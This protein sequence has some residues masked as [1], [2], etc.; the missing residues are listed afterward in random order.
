MN[1]RNGYLRWRGA[2][3]IATTVCLVLLA[4]SVSS[5]VG[6]QSGEVTLTK[7]D[8]NQPEAQPGTVLVQQ[9]SALPNGNED[10]EEQA[11]TDL[12][13]RSSESGFRVFEAGSSEDG[14]E[15]K[16]C[17]VQAVIDEENPDELV[18]GSETCFVNESSADEFAIGRSAHGVSGATGSKNPHILGKHYTGLDFS[19][20]SLTITGTKDC[21]GGGITLSLNPRWNNVIKSTSNGCSR[22]AHY[23]ESQ[24]FI[25]RGELVNTT[26]VGG[27]IIFRDTSAGVSGIRYYGT[28]NKPVRLVALEV[29]QGLQDWN[30]SITLVRGRKTFVRA[31]FETVNSDEISQISGRL[32]LVNCPGQMLPNSSIGPINHR[33]I[34]LVRSNPTNP[35]N[36]VNYYS[37]LN[38]SLP[39]NWSQCNGTA[40][41][42]LQV[43]GA[44]RTA[45]NESSTSNPSLKSCFAFV[46]IQNVSMPKIMM[47]KLGRNNG[48][49]PYR[50][51]H[52][53][54]REQYGRIYSVMPIP[55]KEFLEFSSNF[56]DYFSDKLVYSNN[57]TG[58]RGLIDL[59]KRMNPLRIFLARAYFEIDA[60]QLLFLGVLPREPND[61][62]DPL[63][64]AG[65]YGRQGRGIP[66]SVASWFTSYS[67]RNADL[68]RPRNTGAHELG[69][70]LGE[71]HATDSDGKVV[72]DKDT[73]SS[74][75]LYPYIYPA[76]P[77]DEAINSVA[78]L[79]LMPPQSTSYTEVWGL[80]IRVAEYINYL[81]D[82]RL[83][84]IS[85]HEVY[86]LMSYCDPNDFGIPLSQGVWMDK[87]HYQRII[88]SINERWENS[89][90]TSDQGHPSD[91]SVS[92]EES[93][94]VTVDFISGDIV[95]SGAEF[96]SINL[97]PI[98]S[99]D[100]GFDVPNSKTGD[101]SLELHDSSGNTL[102][103]ISFETFGSFSEVIDGKTKTTEHFAFWI[104][105]P[106]GYDS[107]AVTKSGQTLTTI[108]VSTNSPTISIT[109]PVAGQ[110]VTNN[111]IEIAWTANDP[112][113]DDLT[114]AVM[115]STDGGET[116]RPIAIGYDKTSLNLNL[117]S[118]PGSSEARFIVSVSDGINSTFASSPIVSTPQHA[119][120]IEIVAPTSGA[121]VT[122]GQ[123]FILSAEGYDLE[124]GNL[125]RSAFTWTSSLSGYLGTGDHILLSAT[126]LATGT[127]QIAVTATDSSGSSVTAFTRVTI[128]RTNSIPVAMDDSV[129]IELGESVFIDVLANDTDTEK[130]IDLTT[131]VVS[132]A[133]SLGVAEVTVSSEGVTGIKYTNDTSGNDSFSYQICDGLDRCST[134]KV[135]VRAGLADCTILGTEENDNLM[136]TTG[137]DI[138]C[139]LGGNDT[140][141]GDD[142]D[143]I[144]RGGAGNDSIKGGPGNDEIYGESG[145]DLI[146]G[147]R[148]EDRLF[149]GGDSDEMYGSSG[150]DFLSGG[151]GDDKLHGDSEN[152]I[153]EGGEGSDDLRGGHGD[154]I[155]R[156]NQGDDTIRGTTGND[157]IHGGSG[158]DS[159]NGGSGNDRIFG[160]DDP[161]VIYADDGDDFVSGGNGSD[162]IFGGNG[163]DILE[164]DDG[165]DEIRGGN[166]QDTIRGG[167][168]NDTIRGN[169]G[170]DTIIGGE[171]NNRILGRTREDRVL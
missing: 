43:I 38:F 99:L 7:L 151:K 78:T 144:I 148:G 11:S 129:D 69:H 27:N 136:G 98:V 157:E 4:A 135:R 134:A 100:S 80:D 14:G 143:D 62:N 51:S 73:E 121:V 66:G 158:S 92:G 165:H 1:S 139:G 152:D 70:L 167:K 166:G 74:G 85:P 42:R 50:V 59:N 119:P 16:H 58:I 168:G 29:T 32:H 95:L 133:P 146:N 76:P 131:F 164:G 6:A 97:D 52:A 25:F 141:E 171:G 81:N 170:A 65:F 24:R 140:I 147:N 123:S 61:E 35:S 71:Y 111:S 15:Y 110:Q 150:K 125:P 37:S 105:D 89:S 124:D 115:Y 109:K 156:G 17:V 47:V 112:D 57:L 126:E 21:E 19:G 130:D 18:L 36:R 23:S 31:F 84:V 34:I 8:F 149:G 159:I 91:A 106:P 79:G 55:R 77:N 54:L 45:C 2:S 88:N 83:A 46:S 72:C 118:I 13:Q 155:I 56:Q 30:N 122:G 26:G 9:D 127:H 107:I 90:H 86:S 49:M 103:S 160:E 108:Q 120:E 117:A 60:D 44:S 94:R 68:G 10:T 114:Y 101:Y 48:D 12:N 169:A 132:E 41:L 93:T 53:E 20:S 145:D 82:T 96:E 87:Y 33:G 137:N 5:P 161:D 162:R 40:T 39:D 163:V 63:G 22:I 102:R 104:N 116:Y 113:G 75:K 67:T 64:L 153:L 154:D 142:G 3:F 28:L 128:S 138:I